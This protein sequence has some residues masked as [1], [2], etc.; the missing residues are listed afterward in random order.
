MLILLSKGGFGGGIFEELRGKS[1]MEGEFLFHNLLTL[2]VILHC[3]IYKE[4]HMSN[5]LLLCWHLIFK[6]ERHKIFFNL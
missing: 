6:L 3:V 5:Y 2:V 1:A 4:L